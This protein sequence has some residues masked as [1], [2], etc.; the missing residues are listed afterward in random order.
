MQND[1]ANTATGMVARSSAITDHTASTNTNHH[2]TGRYG[3]HG[4][5]RRNAP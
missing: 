5:V 1:P 3:F 4:K 2:N